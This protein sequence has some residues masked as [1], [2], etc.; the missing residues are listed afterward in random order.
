MTGR[1]G[2]YNKYSEFF[3]GSTSL[4]EKEGQFLEIESEIVSPNYT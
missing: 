2:Q 1:A 4:T 3:F